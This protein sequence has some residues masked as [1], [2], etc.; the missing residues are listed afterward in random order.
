MKT[1]AGKS[2]SVRP[3]NRTVQITNSDTGRLVTVRK[4]PTLRQALLE[5][6]K[7]TLKPQGNYDAKVVGN[8]LIV[9]TKFHNIKK[10]TALEVYQTPR[11]LKRK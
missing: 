4:A 5:H 3:E 2:K 11:P 10:Y 9:K 8:V 1:T 7:E 6:F